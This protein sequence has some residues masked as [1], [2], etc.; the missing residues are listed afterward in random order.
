MCVYFLSA[1]AIKRILSTYCS[2]NLMN[3]GADAQS[4]S[5]N[6]FQI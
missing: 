6:K 4:L 2:S 3:A 1:Y 5:L